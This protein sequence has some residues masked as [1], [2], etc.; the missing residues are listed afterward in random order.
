MG[1][2]VPQATYLSRLLFTDH[3][4]LVPATPEFLS[5]AIQSTCFSRQIRV[6]V[7]H[8]SRELMGILRTQEKVIVIREKDKRM[9]I[10]RVEPLGASQDPDNDGPQFLG[11]LQQKTPLNGP[12]GHFYQGTTFRDEP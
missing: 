4:R 3:D 9:K 11:R 8:E 5:P 6:E 10:D 2:Q 7:I 1:Q 12:T